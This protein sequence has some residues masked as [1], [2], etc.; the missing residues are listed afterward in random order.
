[1]R[2]LALISVL[3][4]VVLAGRAAFVG[5]VKAGALSKLAVGQQQKSFDL[6]AP[7]GQIISSDGQDMAVGRVVVTVSATPYWVEDPADAARQLAP[8]LQADPAVLEER[9]RQKSGYVVLAKGVDPEAANRAR[10]LE[11]EGVDFTDTEQRFYPLR[12][13]AAQ[14]IG[15]TGAD[16]IGLSGVELQR[17]AALTGEAGFQAEARDPF[18]RPLRIL[19]SREPVPGRTVQLTLD[20]AIQ[21]RTEQVLEE[22]RRRYRAKSAMAIVMRPSDGAILAMAN[23]PGFDPNDRRRLK[24]DLMRNKTVTDTFEPGST[25][26]LVTVTGAL[27]ERLV[28]PETRLGLPTQLEVADRI[29]KDAEERPAVNWSVREILQRSSNIGTVLLA[30]RL[31]PTR[32]QKW[33]DR[34]GFGRLTGV[35]FPGESGGIVV[36]PENWSGS[37]IGNIP[38]GQGD[39]ITLMQLARA[40][41]VPA[42]GGYLVQPHL[43]ARIGARPVAVRSRRRIIPPR[44]A[45]VLNS[46]LR[47]VVG[48][49]GTGGAAKIPGYA[50]A[51]KTGTAQKLDP[52]THEYSHRHYTA[53]FV[54]YVPANRPRLLVAVV[55][56][57]P[58][59][60]IYYGGLVAAPAFEQIASF[61]LLNL[62]IAP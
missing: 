10:A 38:I 8:I 40:Y 61:A 4:L 48:D 31:G 5:T 11:I 35:D 9:L 36:R 2:A 54:G 3:A 56:D 28:S 24:A 39:A 49:D 6:P 33:I 57:E 47:D 42:N 23:V 17:D 46:M 43:V 16:Q 21:E 25:F 62:R 60:G 30:Q 37:S 32:L 29:I 52:K 13:V 59:A 27:Q 12:R 19:G 44:T 34:Y 18:G 15:L 58:S 14:V 45:A 55:V 1:V 20:S 26:K 7:R 53:S 51:G 50:V 41:A 22:T